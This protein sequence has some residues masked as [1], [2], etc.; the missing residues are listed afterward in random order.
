MDLEFSNKTAIV[1]GGGSNIGRAISLV[2]GREGANVVIADIDE[3]QGSKVAGEIKAAGGK[4]VCIKTDCTSLESVRELSQKVL[5]TYGQLHILVDNLGWDQPQYFLET[6]PEFWEKVISMNYRSVLNMLYTFLPHFVEKGY[7]RVVNISSDAGRTGEFREAV[8]AGAKSGVHAFTKAIAREYG[9]HN[10]T[11]NVVCPGSTPPD[12]DQDFGE[13]SMWKEGKVYEM[14]QGEERRK[15]I[16]K[17]YPLRRLG[18]P[19]DIANAVAFLVSDRAN[20]I[21][22]QTLSVSGGYTMVM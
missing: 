3:T 5:N 2:L 21:T 8:Y 16:S 1:T 13:L 12:T 6:K 7:G 19:V 15:Q 17:A 22:G 18:T 20:F 10:I 14:F 4:A 9:R 11:L